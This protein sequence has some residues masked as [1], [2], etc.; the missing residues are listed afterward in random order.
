MKKFIAVLALRSAIVIA[1]LTGIVLCALVY[2]FLVS[3]S[4]SGFAPSGEVSESIEVWVRLAFLWC[5]TAPL[6]VLLVYAFKLSG[7]MNRYKLFSADSVRL[8]SKMSA[9]TFLD[10]VLIALGGVILSTCG[11]DVGLASYIMAAIAAIALSLLL[12]GF[13][14]ILRVKV[15]VCE[16]DVTLPEDEYPTADE[17]AADEIKKDE[18]EAVRAE[19][20]ACADELEAGCTEIAEEKKD[21]NKKK[22]KREKK[23]KNEKS[24]DIKADRK[25]KSA[26]GA[27]F[28]IKLAVLMLAAFGIYAC[29]H[30]L[31]DMAGART[32][33]D[34][35]KPF[36][37]NIGRLWGL[38]FSECMSILYFAALLSVWDGVPSSGKSK[39]KEMKD[40]KKNREAS[41]KLLIFSAVL[42]TAVNALIAI[43][44]ANFN[45]ILFV[46]LSPVLI[47]VAL[48]AVN[49]NYYMNKSAF[50]KENEAEA[51]E[52]EKKFAEDFIK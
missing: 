10:G 42:Y 24:K 31:P 25:P 14:G 13:S 48:I 22:A 11:Y 26:G 44:G 38:I 12:S 3:L 7:L 32:I 37:S 52:Y 47:A 20:E 41:V 21:K 8:L 19:E 16:I 2:P 39:K 15:S 23:Q 46:L 35:G 28:M 27:Y 1:L 5:M 34:N 6:F 9:V 51:L 30:V 18:H 40:E 36:F 4:V 43:S 50:E 49:V 29:V 17:I 33:L 45:D